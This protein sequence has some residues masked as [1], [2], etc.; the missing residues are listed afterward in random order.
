MCIQK[1]VFVCTCSGEGSV[2]KK[3]TFQRMESSKDAAC[4]LG[5]S[6]QEA[7]QSFSYGV[8]LQPAELALI[9]VLGQVGLEHA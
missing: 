6:V 4:Y 3:L 2:L 8:P 9:R 5:I 7:G 1:Q